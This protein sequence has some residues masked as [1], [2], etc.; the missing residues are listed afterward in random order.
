VELCFGKPG[1]K[2]L[3]R[4]AQYARKT[5]SIRIIVIDGI[6]AK[7]VC[8]L[9]KSPEIPSID[10]DRLSQRSPVWIDLDFLKSCRSGFEYSAADARE[11]V[12]Q[13]DHSTTSVHP[14]E[15]GGV[16]SIAFSEPPKN[17]RAFVTSGF[18]ESLQ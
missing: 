13:P 14:V 16:T 4:I 18:L 12:W 8:H 6:L 11:S 10:L 1:S 17:R 15:G 3:I 5:P 7:R 9:F 2:G